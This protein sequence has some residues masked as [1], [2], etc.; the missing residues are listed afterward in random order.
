MNR[1][2]K[3]LIFVRLYYDNQISKE[4]MIKEVDS[5]EE[6]IEFVKNNEGSIIRGLCEQ[7]FLPTL[8]YRIEIE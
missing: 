3:T 1:D 2:Y 4:E 8:D 5:Y 7:F 6:A